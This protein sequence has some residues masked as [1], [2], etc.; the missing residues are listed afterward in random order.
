MNATLEKMTTGEPDPQDA[1]DEMQQEAEKIG[2]RQ[3]T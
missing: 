2:M 3:L 1:A